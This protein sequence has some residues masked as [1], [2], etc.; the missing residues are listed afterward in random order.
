M[1]PEKMMQ[2]YVVDAVRTHLPGV[3]ACRISDGGPGFPDLL[4]LRKS[5]YILVELKRDDKGASLEKP[6]S[7]IYRKEQISWYHG[8]A[9][10]MQYAPPVYTILYVGGT[11]LTWKLTPNLFRI[12]P[13]VDRVYIVADFFAQ[14]TL[15]EIL[16]YLNG[17]L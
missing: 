3:T 1:S 6:V 11:Y 2:R 5:R 14:G 15:R 13:T 12:D 9:G 7:S 17:E 10:D 8:V 16:H 4:I